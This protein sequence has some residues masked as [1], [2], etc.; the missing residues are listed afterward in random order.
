M[1]E[2]NER[3]HP[4]KATPDEIRTLL[5]RLSQDKYGVSAHLAIKRDLEHL[6]S[7]EESRAKA[8]RTTFFVHHDE[9]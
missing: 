7:I 5:M 1:A 9:G 8:A 6:S 3:P 4:D 2:A